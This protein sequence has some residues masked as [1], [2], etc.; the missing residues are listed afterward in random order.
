MRASH[1]GDSCPL[2]ARR[3]PIRRTAPRS[4]LF[5]FN[6]N[7]CESDPPRPEIDQRA[8]VSQEVQTPHTTSAQPAITH[9]TRPRGSSTAGIGLFPAIVDPWVPLE[10][11]E[12]VAQ[13][14]GVELLVQR[15]RHQG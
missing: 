3:L 5:L 13:V 7:S 14:L 4:S 11:A 15:F 1:H 9:R 12:Q 2:R 6:A 8:M 10:I